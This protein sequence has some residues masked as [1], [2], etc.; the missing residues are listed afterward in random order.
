MRGVDSALLREVSASDDEAAEAMA[1]AEAS[2]GFELFGE[3]GS[4]LRAVLI[5]V[6]SAAAV[7]EPRRGL[8]SGAAS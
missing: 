4:V 8:E 7:S 1:S 5:E 6:A 2:G 3:S